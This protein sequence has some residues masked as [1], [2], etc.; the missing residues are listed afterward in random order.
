LANVILDIFF[1]IDQ[2][3]KSEYKDRGSR[4]LAYAFP[5]NSSTQM[6]LHRKEIKKGIH[7]QAHYCYACILDFD[8]G[9]QKLAMM[10]RHP[11][12]LAS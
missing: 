6:K 1:V 7:R 5:V 3:Y 12:Q 2:T 8:Y 9:Y 11:T 4:F 10:E